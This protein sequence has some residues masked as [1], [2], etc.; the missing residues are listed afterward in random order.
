MT[1]TPHLANGL[2]INTHDHPIQRV[3][4]CGDT[5]ADVF[6]GAADWLDS[7]ADKLG[8]VIYVAGTH[9]ELIDGD[10]Q[11]WQLSVFVHADEFKAA[12]RPTLAAD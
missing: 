11:P 12:T 6:R 5:I 8:E 3:A 10:E 7:A 1:S 9:L 4:V 2:T